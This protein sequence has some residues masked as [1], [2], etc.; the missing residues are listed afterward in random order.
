MCVLVDRRFLR[1]IEFLYNLLSSEMVTFTMVMNWVKVKGPVYVFSHLFMPE[2]QGTVKMDVPWNSHCDAICWSLV[3]LQC[4]SDNCVSLLW[5]EGSQYW[6]GWCVPLCILWV[7]SQ[8]WLS[9]WWELLIWFLFRWF[10]LP[11]DLP[12]CT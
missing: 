10:S 3:S 4:I 7:V 8:I 11:S 2:I 5:T 9:Y 1:K 12:D 6:C